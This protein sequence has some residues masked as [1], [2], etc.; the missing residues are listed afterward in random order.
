LFRATACLEN[1]NGAIDA[2]VKTWAAIA[3]ESKCSVELAHHVRKPNNGSAA[4]DFDV[5]DARG[6]SSLI[7][8]ARSARVLNVMSK[9]EAEAA[10]VPETSRRAYFRCESR[11]GKANMRPASDE[12]DWHKFISVSLENETTDDPADEVGVVIAWKRPGLFD[13]MTT[14]SLFTVQKAIAARQW[15]EDHRSPDWAG[16]AVASVLGHGASRQD[17]DQGNAE[18]LDQKQSSQDRRK[19]RP[20]SPL[21]IIR[22]S[23]T[24][25]N[26]MTAANIAASGGPKNTSQVAAVVRRSPIRFRG[27]PHCPLAAELASVEMRHS[28]TAAAKVRKPD[29]PWIV[30]NPHPP[31]EASVHFDSGAIQ[32]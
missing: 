22:R 30:L 23:R 32:L 9:E 1:D 25:G 11:N 12:T 17:E 24:M 31:D 26:V 10:G 28:R 7:G 19:T 29:K 15:R 13:G 8:G 5:N 4:A 2:V 6:A 20:R 3:E 14:A 18:G 27:L 21:Q 16:N